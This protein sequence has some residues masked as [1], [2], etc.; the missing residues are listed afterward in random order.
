MLDVLKGWHPVK[1]S[2]GACAERYTISSIICQR[3]FAGW[4]LSDVVYQKDRCY[5]ILLV[6]WNAEQR[7]SAIGKKDVSLSLDSTEMLMSYK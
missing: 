2:G 1:S 5:H 7:G 6:R 4:R 3:M